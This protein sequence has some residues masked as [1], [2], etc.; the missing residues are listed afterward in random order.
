MSMTTVPV[1]EGDASAL[2]AA[3]TMAAGQLMETIAREN[4]ALKGRTRARL[5]ALAE[6]KATATRLYQ[7]HL[8]ELEQA[9]QGY[10]TLS[11]AQRKA[12]QQASALLA[13]EA[14][15]NARLL[16]VAVAI[17]RRFMACVADAARALTAGTPGY[18]STGAL[19]DGPRPTARAPALALDRSL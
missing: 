14:E 6:E 3:V 11:I 18:S 16:K 12:L 5:A 19:G 17:S 7:Q 10:R 15:E 8:A 4:T 1:P 13:Q 9:T 2:V